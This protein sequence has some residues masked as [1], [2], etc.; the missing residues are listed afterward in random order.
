MQLTKI[1]NYR[2]QLA[3]YH[4]K[5]LEDHDPLRIS[6][7]EGDVVVIAASDYENLIENLYILKD[8]VTMNSLLNSRRDM[9]Q[10][11]FDGVSLKDAFHDLM[12]NQN[13]QTSKR[14]SRLV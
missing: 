2:G 3:K 7:T 4:K 12:D 13:K 10:G 11:T 5:I 6:G 9:A 1:S 8:K 14:R